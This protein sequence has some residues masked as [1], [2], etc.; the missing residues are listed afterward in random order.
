MICDMANHTAPSLRALRGL[1]LSALLTLPGCATARSADPDLEP[2][3]TRGVVTSPAQGAHVEINPSDGGS[4]HVLP[5]GAA[6]LW[7]ALPG[8]YDR[9]GFKV[10]QLDAARRT[11]GARR[12]PSGRPIAG[13]EITALMNCGSGLGGNNAARYDVTIDL[14]TRLTPRGDSTLVKLQVV[15]TARSTMNAGDPVGCL[16]TPAMHRLVI[17]ELSTTAA[18]VGP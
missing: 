17:R 9:L 1:A 3:P 2:P 18:I 7:K 15:G 11:L 16:G 5:H 12:A 6:Q 14:L 13:Q 4:E 8:V 10:S